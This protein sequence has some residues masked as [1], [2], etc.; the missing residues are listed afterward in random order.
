MQFN[1]FQNTLYNLKNYGQK[2]FEEIYFKNG[3]PQLQSKPN[4]L[5]RIIRYLFLGGYREK[6]TA[7]KVINFLEE[8][9][10]LLH[11]KSDIENIKTAFTNKFTNIQDKND[12]EESFDGLITQI[13][14]VARENPVFEVAIPIPV[15][16]L[17]PRIVDVPDDGNCLLY[18]IAVGLGTHYKDH[19]EIQHKL[20]W[21]VDPDQLTE[22]FPVL[23]EM[24]KEILADPAKKLRAQAAEYLEQNQ[25][26]LA[27][28]L[29]E[30]VE[31]QREASLEQ[32]NSAK[33]TLEILTAELKQAELD[34]QNAHQEVKNAIDHPQEELQEV[35]LA[36]LYEQVEVFQ[37]KLDDAIEKVRQATASIQLDAEKVSNEATIQKYLQLSKKEGF[38]TGTAQ[39]LALSKV[40]NIPICIISSEGAPQTLNGE[41][42]LPTLTIK[43][44]GGNHFQFVSQG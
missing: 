37:K 32:I 38:F 31:S 15:R 44:V 25:Q 24:G 5:F 6:E 18:A 12:V 20:G 16:A 14:S 40:Y 9:K 10:G 28:V 3:T 42:P 35:I 22:L 26:D 36:S 4:F 23:K 33:S 8:N 43:H 13:Q 29:L 39:I 30:A 27:D 21:N 2:G 41:S 7:L 17:A 11:N 34:L 19:P 1:N